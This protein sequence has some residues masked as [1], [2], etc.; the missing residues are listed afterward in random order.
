MDPKS[1]ARRA[2]RGDLALDSLS[3][4]TLHGPPRTST[5]ARLGQQRGDSLLRSQK[6]CFRAGVAAPVPFAQHAGNHPRHAAKWSEAACPVGCIACWAAV[7]EP[8]FGPYL[9]TEPWGIARI[10]CPAPQP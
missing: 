8:R 10:I 4:P 1:S 3:V 5:A 2:F 6:G 9:F 7:R